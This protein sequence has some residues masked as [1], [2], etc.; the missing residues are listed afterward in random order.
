LL[1]SAAAWAQDPIQVHRY[2]QGRFTDQEGVLDRR[3]IRRARLIVFG[4]PFSELSY[5]V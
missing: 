3:E 1:L 4:D 2:I 5:N